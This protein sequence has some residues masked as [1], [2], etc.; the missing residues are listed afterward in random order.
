MITTTK[1]SPTQKL[2]DLIEDRS[3]GFVSCE[4]LHNELLDLERK[5]GLPLTHPDEDRD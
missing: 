5:L 4:D 1:T 3:L 2:R